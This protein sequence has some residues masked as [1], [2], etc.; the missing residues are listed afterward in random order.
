MNF[1]G[2]GVFFRKLFHKVLDMLDILPNHISDLLVCFRWFINSHIIK[3][4]VS[5]LRTLTSSATNSNL[6]QNSVMSFSKVH[7]LCKNFMFSWRKWKMCVKMEFLDVNNQEGRWFTWTCGSLP[8]WIVPCPCKAPV[9]PSVADAR[10]Q[11]WLYILSRNYI[12]TSFILSI[13]VWKF[14]AYSR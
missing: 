6:H 11:I 12:L 2:R 13:D 10:A 4:L 9:S 8:G 3:E 14:F 7:P 5:W 1:T